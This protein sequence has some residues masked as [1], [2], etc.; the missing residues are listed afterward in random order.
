M[1]RIITKITLALLA[2]TMMGGQLHAQFSTTYAKN[3]T[4]GQ[5]NGLYYSLPQTMLK[6]DFVM[7]EIQME[8]SPY[9]DYASNYMG[10]AESVEYETRQYRLLDVKMSTVASPDPNALFFV[11][12]GSAR[13]GSKM[14]FDIMPNGIIRS[15]GFDDPAAEDIAPVAPQQ[16]SCEEKE[17]T[18]PKSNLID[19]VS[20]GKSNAQL[21]KEVADKIEE[22]RKA[23]FNLISGYYET[24]FNPETFKL[25]YEKLDAMEEEYTNLLLGNHVKKT[26]VKTVYVIPNKEV[27]TQTVAKFSESEGVTVGTSGSGTPI[28]VQTLSMNTTAAINAPSQSAVELMSYENKVFYRL[29]EMANVKVTLG[30]DTLIEDRVVVNQL[31]AVLMAPLTNTRLVFDTETGQI[32]NMRM[33]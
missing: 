12:L 15:V 13:G 30:R 32:I 14:R 26:V 33:Q 7:E 27:P 10:T 31:G 2:L 5:H 22:I 8:R 11:T 19:L 29:P 23:K 6:L 28:M 3:V 18:Y 16:S 21:A 17:T 9:S 1:N 20:M 4:P 24:A 25:M